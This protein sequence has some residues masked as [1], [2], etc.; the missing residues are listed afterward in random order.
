MLGFRAYP[1]E[2]GGPWGSPEQ[3]SAEFLMCS[4]VQRS[5]DWCGEWERDVGQGKGGR[6]AEDRAVG[7]ER[8]GG[9][10]LIR[11]FKI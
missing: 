3:F 2:G 1:G 5:G 6:D 4:A 8:R 11:D 9:L 10:R 7:M